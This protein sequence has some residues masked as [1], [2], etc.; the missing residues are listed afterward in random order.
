MLFYRVVFDVGTSLNPGVDIGQIEGAGMQGIGL[1]VYERW[2]FDPV[3]GQP[4]Q[5]SDQYCL[6]R[7]QDV[8]RGWDIE[9]MKGVPNPRSAY[10]SKGI[11]E[12]PLGLG[13]MYCICDTVMFSERLLGCE[14]CRCCLS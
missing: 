1:Y 12:P 6:P 7:P 4:L 13:S 9:L 8:P 2:S 5:N 14:V 10:S 11:G 3:N